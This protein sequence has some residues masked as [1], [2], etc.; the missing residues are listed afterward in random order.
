MLITLIGNTVT[1]I[2]FTECSYRDRL[3]ERMPRL[4][5][6]LFVYIFNWPYAICYEE[7]LLMHLFFIGAHD[8][9]AKEMDEM[10]ERYTQYHNCS[11]ITPWKNNLNFLQVVCIYL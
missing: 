4:I 9:S 10:V 5:S 2:S 7:C 6:F 8:L 3:I 11:N 1:F